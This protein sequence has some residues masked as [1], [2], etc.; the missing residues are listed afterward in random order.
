MSD[1]PAARRRL[2]ALDDLRGRRSFR[3]TFEEEGIQREG[4][5]AWVGE[6]VVAYENVCRHLPLSLD[7]GDGEFFTSDQTHFICQTHGAIY[8]PGSGLCVA[9]P[10]Q[11]ASLKRLQIEISEGAV[12][13]LG[14]AP[15]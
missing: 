13:F 14:R 9:G 11:G 4:F 12:W 5:L 7:Y 15:E 10:C 3:F 8:E 6:S 1:T 2:I